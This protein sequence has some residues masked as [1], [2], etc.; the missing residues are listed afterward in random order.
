MRKKGIT[1][2]CLLGLLAFAITFLSPCST[3]KEPETWF[4]RVLITNDDGINTPGIL[5]LAKAFSKVAETYVVAPMQNKS[6]ST[7]YMSALST[8]KLTIEKRDLGEGIQAYAV[9]GFPADCVMIA[10]GGIMR[11]NPPDVVIS[12]INTGANLGIAWIGSG[13]I[14]AA[15]VASFAG[16]PALAVSGVDD[17]IPGALE[18]ASR[19]IVQ[20]AQSP[21]FR[22]LGKNQFLTVDIPDILPSEI[23]GIQV[24]KRAGLGGELIFKKAD[25]PEGAKASKQEV[26]RMRLTQ[27]RGAILPNDSDIALYKKGYIVIVPMRADEHDYDLLAKFKQDLSLWPA[28]TK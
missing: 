10:V 20:L 15:R 7:H 12:G 2:L 6:G 4:K 19:W 25:T 17:D 24:A 13:T 21:S 23:Q 5:E 22:D 27:D 3:Q 28:W 9:D 8:G 11:D 18:A 1:I 16:F 26:W 14:G